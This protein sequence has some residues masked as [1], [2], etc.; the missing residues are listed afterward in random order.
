MSLLETTGWRIVW[1]KALKFW[2]LRVKLWDKLGRAWLQRIPYA[3]LFLKHRSL[4]WVSPTGNWFLV[5]GYWFLLDNITF[6]LTCKNC[7]VAVS[8]WRFF[9]VQLK[10]L[11][12]RSMSYSLRVFVLHWWCVCRKVPVLQWKRYCWVVFLLQWKGP[13]RITDRSM[14]FSL[15]VFVGG[16]IMQ[17][18][19][20]CHAASGFLSTL[21]RFNHLKNKFLNSCCVCVWVCVR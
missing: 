16:S 8:S 9:V 12:S 7:C 2:K 18:I 21:F 3:V 10:G 19:D 20:C 11:C 6:T 5:P 13:C 4:C 14:S 1:H 15:S 17:W